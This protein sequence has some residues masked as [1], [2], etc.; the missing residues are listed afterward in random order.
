MACWIYPLN[1]TG[2]FSRMPPEVT[3]THRPVGIAVLGVLYPQQIWERGKENPKL[4]E[5]IERVMVW[6]KNTQ[7]KLHIVAAVISSKSDAENTKFRWLISLLLQF[8][9]VNPLSLATT[10]RLPNFES[11]HWG[12][13]NPE[14][15]GDGFRYC[16]LDPS[17]GPLTPGLPWGI[18]T[19]S[20]WFYKCWNIKEQKP[21]FPI[22]WGM[23]RC[24]LWWVQSR[25]AE[26]SP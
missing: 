19:V 16:E 13:N 1:P 11:G 25:V 23:F 3:T 26:T 17:W 15:K 7:L 12:R 22:S 21:T 6:K 4:R 9:A 20:Q 5:L 18:P 10:A 8:H 2:W 14:F 24:F